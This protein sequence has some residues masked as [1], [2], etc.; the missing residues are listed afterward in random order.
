MGIVDDLVH[1]QVFVA[2]V[3]SWT[4]GRL[5]KL[6]VT[7]DEDGTFEW[8]DIFSSGGMPSIHSAQVCAIMLTIGFVE[9][10]GSSLFGLS[11]VLAGIVMYDAVGVRQATGKQA[12][13]LNHLLKRVGSDMDFK[14]QRLSERVGHTLPQVLVGATLGSV[15][16]V[17]LELL[18]K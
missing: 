13:I 14:P 1:N 9:G 2:A 18:W 5:A 8:T 17:V 7:R 4:L 16:A 15:I 10:F 12:E 3:L 6:L 11:T